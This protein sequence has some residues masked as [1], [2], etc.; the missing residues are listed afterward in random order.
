MNLNIQNIVKICSLVPMQDSSSL[1]LGTR[2]DE[3]RKEKYNVGYYLCKNVAHYLS[4]L[5]FS[6]E[7]GSG[8]KTSRTELSTLTHFA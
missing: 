2:L 6:L 1:C 8:D 7:E 4:L 3:I 5:L